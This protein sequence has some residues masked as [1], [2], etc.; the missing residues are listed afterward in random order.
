MCRRLAPSFRQLQTR[1]HNL[2]MKQ[3]TTFLVSEPEAAHPDNFAI[4]SSG[5]QV[6]SLPA[7][8][9]D[10]LTISFQEL[11]TDIQSGLEQC[12]ELV[13]HWAT[14]RKYETSNPYAARVPPGLHVFVTPLADSPPY[15][16]LFFWCW[17]HR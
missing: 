9:E 16:S 10:H 15:V 13:I 8:R 6:K 4:S 7:I 5:F 2:T 12:K 3:R 14:G 1:L 17:L 11:P